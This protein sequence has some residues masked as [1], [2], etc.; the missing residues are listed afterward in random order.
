MT[1]QRRLSYSLSAAALLL[2]LLLGSAGFAQDKAAAQTTKANSWTVQIEPVAWDEGK[3]PPDFAVAIYEKLIQ[4]IGKTGKFKQIYRIGDRRAADAPNL[5]VLTSKVENF[6]LGSETKRAV[7]TV[8][9]ATKIS[10]RVQLTTRDS[11][12][13]MDKTATGTVRFMGGNLNA[14]QDLAKNIAKLI[15][16]SSL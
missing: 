13:K 11:Q 12:V 6:Q 7:T 15:K 8:Q 2:M 5:L 16:E 1:S 4:E 9:G 10:V 3:I 14:T